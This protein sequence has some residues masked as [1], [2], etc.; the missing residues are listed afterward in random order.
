VTGVIIDACVMGPL[1]IPDESD[2]EHPALKDVLR[3]GI[4]TVPG[5]WHLEVANLGMSAMR[6]KRLEED[7]LRARLADFGMFEIAVDDATATNAWQRTTFLSL[8]H[9]LTIYDAAYL[10]LAL[11]LSGPL[12]TS[13]TDL[14]NAAAAERVELL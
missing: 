5:H 9:G 8:A 10:E 6:R 4:A 2:G 3:S 1:L 13:D 14:R 11:R 7:E 12:L